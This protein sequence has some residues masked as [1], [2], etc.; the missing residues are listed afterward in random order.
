VHVAD[1][2]KGEHAL[3]RQSRQKNVC[4]VRCARLS[5]SAFSSRATV[6]IHRWPI[7]F[8]DVIRA[9]STLS[10][11]KH[12]QRL[13]ELTANR[14]SDIRLCDPKEVRVVI[15]EYMRIEARL[16]D[17]SRLPDT[18]FE[19]PICKDGCRVLCV[20]GIFKLW[21]Y[22]TA[23]ASGAGLEP[24]SGAIPGQMGSLF[25]SAEVVD[26]VF[27]ALESQGVNLRSTCGSAEIDAMA[28]K[29]HSAR[30]MMA[31]HGTYMACCMHGI[32]FKA[33]DFTGG[34]K[35]SFPLVMYLLCQKPVQVLVGDSLCRC[36]N[37]FH[38]ADEHRDEIIPKLPDGL[39]WLDCD[40]SLAVNALH[41]K[42]VRTDC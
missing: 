20:D 35:A 29:S 13:N 8:L 7:P 23:A 33:Y 11:D 5:A 22:K 30:H 28:G 36:G 6:H 26:R 41:V 14:G 18:N 17:L 34:E 3:H 32:L 27:T 15:R 38:Q 21:Q 9:T 39:R 40:L 37:V 42:G 25:E 2:D 16:A 19:C 1:T 24:V 31:V 4:A 12:A 10:A